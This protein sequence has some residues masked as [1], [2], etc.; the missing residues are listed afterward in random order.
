MK[1]N[2]LISE[3]YYDVNPKLEPFVKMGRKITAA[4]S[5]G[6]DVDWQDDEQWNTAAT[7]G[8]ALT[9]LGS[10]FGPSTPAEA[11]KKA[12]VD[13]DTA[14]EIF[15]MVKDIDPGKFA[16]EDPEDDEEDEEPEDQEPEDFV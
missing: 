11:L 7:L 9:S 5:P 1:M 14:K 3:G 10:D 13:V 2:E 4:I 16:P 12:G 8:S 15:A 6:S